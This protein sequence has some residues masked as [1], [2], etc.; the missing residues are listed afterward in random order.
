M[1]RLPAGATV[2]TAV[3][4]GNDGAGGSVRTIPYAAAISS[5]TSTTP[6]ILWNVFM[7]SRL[8]RVILI[9]ITEEGTTDREEKWVGRSGR[10]L[11]AR[12]G[13]Y[14]GVE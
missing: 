14:R 7:A 4:P 3:L 1:A 12:G 11:T 5:N 8:G 2:S 9:C 10:E 6:A 13:L